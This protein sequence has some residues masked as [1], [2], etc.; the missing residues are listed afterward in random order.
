MKPARK[1]TSRSSRRPLIGV[2]LGDP[3]GIGPEVVRKALASPRVKNACEILLFG[4]SSYYDWK[5]AQKLTPAQCGKLAGYYIQEAARS[6]LRGSIDAIAT[7]PISKEH[8]NL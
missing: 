4:D 3:K 6:A 7:A 5:R 1:P 8:L 2:T